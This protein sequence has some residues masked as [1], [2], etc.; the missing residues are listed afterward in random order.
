MLPNPASWP[1]ERML[2]AATDVTDTVDVAPNGT[3]KINDASS[4]LTFGDAYEQMIFESNG[5]NW[6]RKVTTAA[7]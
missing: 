2:V 1:S 6:Y 3:E 5:T 7:T 4:I